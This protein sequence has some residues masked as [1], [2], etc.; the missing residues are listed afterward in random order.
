MA[1]YRGN[2]Y[3]LHVAV[4]L[5]AIS[6]LENPPQRGRQFLLFDM[7]TKIRSDISRLQHHGDVICQPQSFEPH[8]SV[9]LGEPK[10]LACKGI[11]RNNFFGQYL[12]GRNQTHFSHVLGEAQNFAQITF[13]FLAPDNSALA[14]FAF[15]KIILKQN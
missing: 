1:G 4:G 11:G 10:A 2:R 5:E 14:G 7:G 3:T 13:N 9:P 15:Q 12:G 8:D 6:F